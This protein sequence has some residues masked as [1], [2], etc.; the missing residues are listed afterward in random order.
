MWVKKKSFDTEL[1]KVLTVLEADQKESEKLEGVINDRELKQIFHQLIRNEQ[2]YADQLLVNLSVEC[3]KSFEFEARRSKNHNEVNGIK[4]SCKEELFEKCKKKEMAI[5]KTYMEA[6]DSCS[7][8]KR[9]GRI[10]QE[11][12]NELKILFLKIR[13][14]YMVKSKLISP[15]DLRKV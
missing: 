4:F 2:E 1:I 9:I 7:F 12:L 6:I 15:Y 8:H 14:N 10:M 13:I 11:Q 3:Q 5:A